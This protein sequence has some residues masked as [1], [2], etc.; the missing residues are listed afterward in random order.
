MTLLIHLMAFSQSSKRLMKCKELQIFI[1]Q[2]PLMI[3]ENVDLVKTRYWHCTMV[4]DV[5]HHLKYVYYH[6]YHYYYYYYYYCALCRASWL[7]IC[8]YK[9]YH[10]L[11]DTTG[12]TNRTTKMTAIFMLNIFYFII[13]HF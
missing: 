10:S 6:Y 13:L 2:P 12:I 5:C 9:S 7:L 1:S 11:L 4:Y 8:C 3:C